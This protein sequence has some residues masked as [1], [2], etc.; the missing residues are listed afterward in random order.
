MKYEQ[1]IETLN[2]NHFYPDTVTKDGKIT[3]LH[4]NALPNMMGDNKKRLEEVLADA[5]VKI[6][7]MPNEG[8]ISIIKKIK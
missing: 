3:E 7:T 1:I 8:Y 2:S 5:E 4:V 6:T